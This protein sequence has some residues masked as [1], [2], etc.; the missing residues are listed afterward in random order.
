MDSIITKQT[1]KVISVNGNA[2]V[3]VNGK[4][5][6]LADMAEINAGTKIFLPEGATAI[7]TL[8]DGNILP[9]GQNVESNES[10]T[11][12][13]TADEIAALQDLIA[14]GIDPTEDLEAPAAG[15]TPASGAG[16]WSAV[17]ISRDGAETIAQ[18]GF[19]TSGIANDFGTAAVF[20]EENTGIS[21]A[22]DA[23]TPPTPEPTIDATFTLSSTTNGENVVEGGQI[24]Y[25]VTLDQIAQENIT[26]SLSNGETIL[27]AAGETSGSVTVDVR[28]DDLYKQDNDE[29]SVTIDSISENS[30]DSSTPEGTITNTVVDDSDSTTLSL[31]LSSNTV[32]EGGTLTLTVSVD[33]APQSTD[34]KVTLS[35]GQVV[36]IPA[37]ETS[38][39]VDYTPQRAD[40]L[41]VQGNTTET[42]SVT[43]T[44]GGNYE[45]LNTQATSDVIVKD[46]EDTVLVNISGPDSVVEGETTGKYTVSLTQKAE[47]PV[48]VK[49][50][51]S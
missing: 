18:A 23:V 13:T 29:I 1:A 47:T 27:V 10:N 12:N 17:A 3:L 19:D 32:T 26:V 15:G 25:T 30:F 49:L 44:E 24:T 48:T 43:K 42:L 9:I 7:L 31:K 20:R 35:N 50:T 4:S 11:P 36:T 40:D 41:Y 33:N 2:Y 46:D 51:Y 21:D 6:A 8:E 5:I 38:V 39:T 37:G 34:L 14:Q 45:S 16:S 22:E 28:E